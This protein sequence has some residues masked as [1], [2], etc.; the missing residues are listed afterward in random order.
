[1]LGT[2]LVTLLFEKWLHMRA[3]Q[4]LMGGRCCS[5]THHS[6]RLRFLEG[7]LTSGFCRGIRISPTRSGQ[8]GLVIRSI[9]WWFVRRMP[10]LPKLFPCFRVGM[11]TRPTHREA[12][13]LASELL[14]QRPALYK[15]KNSNNISIV[16]YRNAAMWNSTFIS[17]IG[18]VGCHDSYKRG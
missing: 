1:M 9:A 14:S 15:N 18:L 4:H 2:R 3:N 17:N 8:C 12:C 11:W 6:A 10:F 5:F 13:D 7:E 16:W